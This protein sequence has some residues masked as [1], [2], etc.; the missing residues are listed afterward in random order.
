MKKFKLIF[1]S[2]F[3]TV[4]LVGN[5]YAVP[6]NINFDPSN[7][8]TFFETALMHFN[9]YPIAGSNPV[10]IIQQL[11]ADGYLGNGDLFTEG[12]T[13]NIDYIAGPN[14][15]FF[16]PYSN[17]YLDI[18]L[19]GHIANFSGPADISAADGA[20]INTKLAT[21][22]YDILFTGGT[23]KFYSPL[24][25]NVLLATLNLV[26]GGG[27]DALFVTSSVIN[28]DFG[29]VF[30]FDSYLTTAFNLPADQELILAVATGSARFLGTVGDTN[31]TE[32]TSDDSIIFSVY[33]QG[34][35]ITFSQI[36]EPTTM[37]L[38]GFGLLGLAGVT[39]RKK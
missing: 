25:G 14:S 8:S 28:N 22:S 10:Q 34:G 30:E 6:T 15:P 23:A 26:S 32:D 29:A 18:S 1:L 36:P 12:W 19:N 21:A 2:A 9:T 17:V 38:L 27:D 11:G 39:R 33:D 31:G 4:L 24:S 5:V 7:S 16:I 35:I 37:V 13:T 3:L 20:G